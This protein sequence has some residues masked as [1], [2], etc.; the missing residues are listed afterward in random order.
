MDG[1]VCAQTC[2]RDLINNIY[3]HIYSICVHYILYVYI[4]Y[5]CVCVFNSVCAFSCCIKDNSC[6][7]KNAWNGKLHGCLFCVRF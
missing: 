4:E 5:I 2:G 6:C 7:T 3:I 1:A